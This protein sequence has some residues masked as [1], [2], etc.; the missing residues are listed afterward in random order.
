R[1]V[2]K[3]AGRIFG[4]ANAPDI[5]NYCYRDFYETPRD[6]YVLFRQPGGLE[7]NAEN[8]KVMGREYYENSARVNAHR[9]WWVRRMVH[10]K[11]GFTRDVDVVYAE[12][13][14]D[15]NM[16]RVPIEVTRMLPVV[17]GVDGGLTPSAIYSQVVGRQGRIL[18][19]IVLE[20][21][22]MRELADAMLE[23]EAQRF[24][25]CEFA[26][27]CDPAMAAGEDTAEKSDRARLSEYLGR[28]VMSADTNDPGRR[29][30]A[31]KAYLART[32]ENGRPGLI[33]DPSC[34]A[35][36]RGF[37]QT[38]HY[39]RTRGTN[40]LARIEKTRDSHPHDALQYGALAWGTD[41]ATKRTSEQ[42][43]DLNR[44]RQQ[45]REAGR[46]NPL[47]RRA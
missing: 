5:E 24:R 29:I 46:Y 19:E 6:G 28:T 47:R 15:R 13:D 45:A 1:A 4:D 37:N 25:G 43:R 38:Y 30:E 39:A 7:S 20:R 3:R 42:V 35:L 36:R 14:D 31:V 33:V 32:L 26:D 41:A 11:P 27:F 17:V 44:R 34:K 21:G 22:G 16:A 8:I 12:F 40:D 23:L 9:P 2:I 10:A 18:A